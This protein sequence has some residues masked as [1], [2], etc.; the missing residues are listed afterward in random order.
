MAVNDFASLLLGEAGGKTSAQ[1][2]NDMLHIASVVVNRAASTGRPVEDIIANQREFNA[3]GKALPPDTAQYRTLAE[4]AIRQVLREGPVTTATFYATPETTKNLPSGLNTATRTASHEYFTDPQNRAIGTASGYAPVTPVNIETVP[5]V[6]ITAPVPYGPMD[7]RMEPFQPQYADL[8]PPTAGPP[9]REIAPGAGLANLVPAAP[10][11]V[12]G[13][14]YGSIAYAHPERGPWDTGMTPAAVE[15]VNIM[16]AGS[17]AGASITS[18]YRPPSVNA[19]VGGARGSQH[20]AGNAYDLDLRGLDTQERAAAVE[21][22][23]MSGATR[24][25]SY[26]REPNMLHVDFASGY[27]PTHGTVYAMHDRSNRNMARAPDWFT[28]GLSQVTVPTPTPRPDLPAAAATAPSSIPVF[29]GGASPRLGQEE[30]MAMYG[31]SLPREAAVPEVPALPFAPASPSFQQGPMSA[32]GTMGAPMSVPGATPSVADAYRDYGQSRMQAPSVP[33]VPEI[34]ASV[35]QA[36]P[37]MPAVPEFA[38]PDMAPIPSSSPRNGFND[39]KRG[40][41]G[42]LGAAIAA[43]AIAQIGRNIRSNAQGQRINVFAGIPQAYRSAAAG[44]RG[45]L[46][47]AFGSRPAPAQFSVGTGLNAI[48]AALNSRTP[49]AT[50]Y[51]ASHPGASVS[52]NAY[53]LPEFTSQH[54]FSGVAPAGFFS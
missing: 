21:R 3:W 9:A 26:T 2:Y 8:V 32:P 46:D 23:M 11:A 36:I 14:G 1:R 5:P 45:R 7:M 13:S 48:Q 19:A 27:A 28:S 53:G 31:L 12:P 33:A 25:G 18:A 49:G 54:G 34:T 29:S 17:P 40:A 50:A 20:K 10:P 6:P 15:S 44:I 22:A 4:Q 38:L 39:M 43:P 35:P 42:G 52:V 37:A 30:S 16:A 24:L 47:G 41:L 51:S